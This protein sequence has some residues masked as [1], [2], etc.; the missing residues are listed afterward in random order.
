MREALVNSGIKLSM[1]RLS[2]KHSNKAQKDSY[3]FLNLLELPLALPAKKR[4]YL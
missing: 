4:I 3:E 2:G 1:D